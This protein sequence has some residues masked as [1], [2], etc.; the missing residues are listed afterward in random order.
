MKLRMKRL[1]LSGAV[2]WVIAAVGT[3]LARQS[4]TYSGPQTQRTWLSMLVPFEG[5]AFAQGRA[6]A[7]ATPQMSDVAFKNIQVLKGIPVDEFMGTM[8]LFSAA[9]SVCCGDCHTGAGTDNPDWAA[10]PPRK[11]TARRMVE[12]VN[13]INKT[14]FNGRQVVTCWTCHRGAQ[15][16]AAT[17]AIDTI[18]ST[19]VFLPPDILP[20]AN[21]ATAGTPP[22]DQILDNYIKALGGADAL[23]KLTSFTAKGTSEL[24]GEAKPEPAE[25]YAK[26]PNQL[27]TIVHQRGGDLA[28]TF[29][30]RDAWVMLPLTVVGEYPLAGSAREGGRL[31]A[32]MAFPAGLKQFFKSW[33]VTY[34]ATIDEKDVYVIQGAGDNGL[35]GTFYFDKKTGLLTRMVRMVNSAVG[36]VPTQIDYSD[37]RRVAGVM[38]P[39]KFTY[40]W[41]SGRED[42]VL[43]EIQPNVPVDAAKFAKPVQR[44]K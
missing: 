29:D 44:A 34:P 6:Q 15:N 36:R 33:K 5:V 35:L 40:G 24:F 27:A 39:Y 3:N 2:A 41:V 18:Y 19:P 28:R 10:D 7:G 4:S 13:T 42:Y 14:N 9:L 21:P 25:I 17:P 32:Q 26:A 1:V 30:G 11:R 22:A 31:D 12:M 37:Y 23:A 38:M 20:T 43:S 16:P 8:G